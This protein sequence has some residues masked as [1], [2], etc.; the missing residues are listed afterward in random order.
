[1]AV[2]WV[3]GGLVGLSTTRATGTGRRLGS[4][5]MAQGWPKDGPGMGARQKGTMPPDRILT[6][7]WAQRYYY[8]YVLRFRPRGEEEPIIS[9]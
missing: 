1:M 3:W 8:Y 6:R 5:R 2:R 9:A 7:A 4:T